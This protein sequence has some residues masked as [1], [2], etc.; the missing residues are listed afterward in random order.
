MDEIE[1]SLEFSKRRPTWTPEGFPLWL[2]DGEPWILPRGRWDWPVLDPFRDAIFDMWVLRGASRLHESVMPE[3]ALAAGLLLRANY[4]LTSDEAAQAI[5]PVPKDQLIYAVVNCILTPEPEKIGYSE[6]VRSGLLA[7]GL[8]VE[9]IP[10]SQIENVISHLT[11]SGR[12][13]P[14]RE[15]I[16]SVAAQEQLAALPR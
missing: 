10:I 2:D 9:D 6:W 14:K 11:C 16:S 1:A 15:F 8:K 4:D 7:N 12:M 13:A 5:R 3:V